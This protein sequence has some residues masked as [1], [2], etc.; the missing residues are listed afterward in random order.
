MG[1]RKAI[2]ICIPLHFRCWLLGDLLL[3][4]GADHRN[5]E[6]G[7][8]IGPKKEKTGRRAAESESEERSSRRAERDWTRWMGFT[9]PFKLPCLCGRVESERWMACLLVVCPPGPCRFQQSCLLLPAC[10]FASY[11]L[12]SFFLSLSLSLSCCCYSYIQ[13]KKGER[14]EWK[15]LWHRND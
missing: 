5:T 6:D 15:A 9:C 13:K 1:L 10:F 14:R 2:E 7:N 4:C 11:K 3:G 8:P 12:T